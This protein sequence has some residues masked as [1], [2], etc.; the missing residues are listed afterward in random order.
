MPLLLCLTGMST[1][2]AESLAIG[3]EEANNM[4]FEYVDEYVQLTGFHI[5]V[6]NSVAKALG[7]QVTY[8]RLP[9]KRAMLALQHDALDAVSFVA[10]SK[11]RERFALFLPDNILPE[12]AKSPVV[13][14][15]DE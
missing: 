8:E 10:K 6:I 1:A 5:D 9:W 7:W 14:G 3:I 12:F 11:D 15:G 2:N 4:P 13:Q